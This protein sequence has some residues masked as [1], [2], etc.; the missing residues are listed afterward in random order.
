MKGFSKI[1][2]KTR[3]LLSVCAL[4]VVSSCV[5][6]ALYSSNSI[7]TSLDGDKAPTVKESGVE[8]VVLDDEKYDLLDGINFVTKVT[9]D[10]TLNKR[11]FHVKII[12][13]ST[14]PQ[15]LTFK[16]GVRFEYFIK[17]MTDTVKHTGFIPLSDTK[18]VVQ[19]DSA[20]IAEY[21]L[22]MTKVF[23]KL[24]DGAYMVEFRT[25][26]D[27][28]KNALYGMSFTKNTQAENT[29]IV[30][31]EV[32]FIKANKDSTV[33]LKVDGEESKWSYNTSLDSFFKRQEKGSVLIIGH[34]QGDTKQVVTV[35]VK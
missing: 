28:V 27:E 9:S 31:S 12:N 16:D 10:T 15:G 14:N 1:T 35:K 21:E 34:T 5:G 8:T 17:D 25:D 24:E 11:V 29:A 19:F 4:V 3:I 26:A 6:Y 30:N 7:K 13:A 32:E 18:Q 33:Q 22:D 2:K 23:S 20:E